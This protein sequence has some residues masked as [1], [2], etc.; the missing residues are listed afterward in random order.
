MDEWAGYLA[1]GGPAGTSAAPLNTT[2][3]PPAGIN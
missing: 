1:N 3:E 2:P